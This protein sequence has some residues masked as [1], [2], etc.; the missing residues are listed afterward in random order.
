MIESR[1]GGSRLINADC[2]GV[3]DKLIADGVKVDAIITDP[4]Y[5]INLKPQ[6]ATGKFKDTLVINDEDIDI[7]KEF[8]IRA[9]KLTDRIYMFTGWKQLGNIQIEFEKHF[10]YKNCIVWDK[11]WFGMGGNW[12]PN[13]EFIMYGISKNKKDSGTILSNSKENIL[14]YRR[15][16]PQKMVHSCEKP[17]KLMEEIIEQCGEVI[18][19][20]F[21]GSGTTGV[22][23]INTNRK[24]IGIE[25]DKG[26][27]EIGKKRMEDRQKEL[28][29]NSELF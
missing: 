9:E 8:L 7:I 4:P 28:D 3:M 14:R 22:A 25:K 18:L 15:V 23:C 10:N 21:M 2:L 27:F 5:G 24:F 6:R 16:T 1:S 17:V 20:P 19:D 11:M 12:R 26:Y 29:F 13:H